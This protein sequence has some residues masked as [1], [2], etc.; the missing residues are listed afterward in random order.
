MKHHI[1]KVIFSVLLFSAPLLF[2]QETLELTLEESVA[3]AKSQN[4]G[5]QAQAK[6]LSSTKRTADGSWSRLLPS[7]TGSYGLNTASRF[8]GEADPLPPGATSPYDNWNYTGSLNLSL[9]LNANVIQRID[10]DKLGY[11]IGT[12]D[13]DIL[14][15]QL[16]R[17]TQNGYFNII[18]QKLNLGILEKNLQASIDRYEQTKVNYQNGLSSELQ[19]LQAQVNSEL[20]KPQLAT[21]Q[22][23][24][25]NNLLTFKTNLQIPVD[26]VLVLT[27]SIDR[28]F[29][30]FDVDVLTEKYLPRSLSLHK[31]DTQI[32]TLRNTKAIL[33]EQSYTPSLNLSAGLNPDSLDPE[34]LDL[35]SSY[36]FGLGFTMPLDPL[37]PYSQQNI[38]WKNADDS[39]K[40]LE[41]QRQQTKDNLTTQL[42]NVIMRMETAIT[43][44]ETSN[45]RLSVAERSYQLTN[46][47]Y[48]NG[49]Q[50]L[51]DVQDAQNSFLSTGQDALQQKYIYL[52][53]LT[54]LEDIL[55]TP[56]TDLLNDKTTL[57]TK[58]N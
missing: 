14:V 44:V 24:Y 40:S 32:K 5:V 52:Q 22:T 15:S 27:D 53:T 16:V 37:I 26:T 21:A 49:L 48:L 42:A 33:F 39:L 36:S 35:G 55:N 47:A 20:L 2:S 12:F 56:I 8:I 34:N 31:I 19:M 4:L 7:I 17:N 10:N 28:P 38:Q 45:F 58:S 3:L 51:L 43:N 18:A 50:E 13:Y 30:H 57:S 11:E 1:N 9:P 46:E 23:T 6:T 41:I 29:V 25:E 54:E